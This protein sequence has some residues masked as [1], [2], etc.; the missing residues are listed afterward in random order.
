MIDELKLR[1]VISQEVNDL[2]HDNLTNIL[3]SLH[4]S[5]EPTIY[6]PTRKIYF[7]EFISIFE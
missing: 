3:A 6:N 7:P 2:D 1:M 5:I 4:N